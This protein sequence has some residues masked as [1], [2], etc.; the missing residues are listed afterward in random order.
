MRHPRILAT[1]LLALAL[2]F[3]SP[4]T[5]FAEEGEEESPATDTQ[6]ILQEQYDLSGASQLEDALP[7]GARDTL[8]DS[9][10]LDGDLTGESALSFLDLPKLLGSLWESIKTTAKEPI[11]ILALIV[12]TILVCA[13]AES[14]KSTFFS[15]SLSP[16][17][18]VV[19]AL[20]IA[21][22]VVAPVYRL[23]QD[24]NQTL[25][26]TNQFIATFAPIYSTVAATSGQ[27][28]TATAYSGVLMLV[29]QGVSAIC[30]STIVP[31]LGLMLAFSVT[32]A[33][34]S[35]LRVSA[36][37]GGLK[38]AVVLLLTLLLTIFCGVLSMQSFVT[39]A[40]DNLAMKT[41]K[42]LI[43][44]MVP[45]VG[46]AVS[47][48]LSS[49]YGCLK[50]VKNGV[51]VFGI[52]AVVVSFVPL[53]L[54]CLLYKA[55]LWAGAFFCDMLGVSSV[56]DTLKSIGNCLTIAVALLFTYALLVIITTVIVM[57]G[58]G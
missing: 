52:A 56:R 10:L 24:L 45:I 41:G 35:D 18:S 58:V 55:T 1:L 57:M 21:V 38:N 51:G 53:L 12:V 43:G 25:L 16:V 33:V 27:P 34:Q 42:L 20:C 19:A 39:S 4:W 31:L 47:D 8:E 32:G 49:V 17:V 2:L 28:L 36:I 26:S 15:E 44:N 37:S 13:M 50:V 11:R 40:S 46:G 7:E 29:V 22:A 54:R 23:I 14:M 30:S 3:F 5:A 9:G 48:A 6:Q